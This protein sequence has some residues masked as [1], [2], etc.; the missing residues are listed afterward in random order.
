MSNDHSLWC[1]DLQCSTISFL[2]CTIQNF[3]LSTFIILRQ[4]KTNDIQ[5]VLL[6][7]F[8]FLK[9]K[10]HTVLHRQQVF[11]NSENL[12]E[13][14][15]AMWEIFY[16]VWIYSFYFRMKNIFLKGMIWVGG[17][18]FITTLARLFNVKICLFYSESIGKYWSFISHKHHLG[19]GKYWLFIF[20][21]VFI[22]LVSIPFWRESYWRCSQYILVPISRA[23]KCTLLHFLNNIIM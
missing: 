10:V 23:M 21:F 15:T 2:H 22:Y 12:Y 5:N 13:T 11:F 20:E 4:Q 3:V 9:Y 17:F 8:T 18:C 7:I 1:N 16:R 19:I 14:G 6:Y